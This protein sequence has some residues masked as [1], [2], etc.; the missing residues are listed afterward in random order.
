MTTGKLH[1][2][3]TKNQAEKISPNKEIL[4]KPGEISPVIS[5]EVRDNKTG[6]VT[7]RGLPRK[8]ESFLVGFMKVFA[9]CLMGAATS[10][11]SHA[12]QFDPEGIK[13]TDYSVGTSQADTTFGQLFTDSDRDFFGLNAIDG[14]ATYGTQIGSGIT[15]PDF[16]DFKIETQIAH[17]AAPGQLQYG[18]Q[19]FGEPSEAGGVSRYRIS[20][21]FSN[22]SGADVNVTEVGVTAKVKFYDYAYVLL[23]RD[24]F[25]G[26]VS[27]PNGQSLTVN[28]DIQAAI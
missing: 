21:I 22:T 12:M 28:Y 19:Y 6:E 11:C 14:D 16:R 7:Q 18:A 15:P 3:H 2:I 13:P 5:W 23:I 20:R 26:V 25:G 4:L 9:T 10:S 17:G 8:S 1:N 24:L 27:V